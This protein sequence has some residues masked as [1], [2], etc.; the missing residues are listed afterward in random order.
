M[1]G[2]VATTLLI[3]IHW[4]THTIGPMP[5]AWSLATEITFY[6]SLPLIARAVRPVLAR[7]PR[8]ERRNGLLLL[9]AGLYLLSVAFRVIVLGIDNRWTPSAVLW[10]AGTFD[11]FAI[12]MTLAVL[13]VALKEGTPGR[14]RLDRRQFLR[15]QRLRR[16]L[17]RLVVRNLRHVRHE[18]IPG[19]V[20][21]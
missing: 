18:G 17:S 5:Q 20:G 15:T 3:H 10:L 8:E 2:A 12:G 21:R 6:A 7:R 16:A 14:R 19:C 1:T 11:Y 13:H 4:P 9:T